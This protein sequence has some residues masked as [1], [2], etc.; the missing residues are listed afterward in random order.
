MLFW[1]FVNCAQ[2]DLSSLV[3]IRSAVL[4]DCM[5]LDRNLLELQSW[6]HFKGQVC[7]TGRTNGSF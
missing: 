2:L 4:T 5:Q 3:G 7:T 6:V 1:A